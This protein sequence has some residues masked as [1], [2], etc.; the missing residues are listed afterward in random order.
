MVAGDASDA[1]L[2]DGEMRAVLPP[3]RP[4]V[5]QSIAAGSLTLSN[6]IARQDMTWGSQGRTHCGT[7]P[8]PVPSP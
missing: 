8:S 7:S 3:L 4:A 5:V 1:S 6:N 2:S